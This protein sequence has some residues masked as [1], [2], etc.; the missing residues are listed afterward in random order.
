MRTEIT[1]DEVG[2]RY[3]IAVERMIQAIVNHSEDHFYNPDG[4]PKMD[5]GQ[6]SAAVDGLITLL[7]HE[8]SLIK[9]TV[10]E[11]YEIN[12]ADKSQKELF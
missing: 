3:G 6:V 12:H 9:D 11:A 1:P 10:Q 8:A 2:D 7:R 5:S 4:S